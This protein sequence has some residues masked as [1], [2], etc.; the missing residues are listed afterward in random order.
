MQRILVHCNQTEGSL[1]DGLKDKHGSAFDRW[2]D[3]QC[4]RVLME[5]AAG[6]VTHA[7]VKA[8]PRGVGVTRTLRLHEDTYEQIRR[9]KLLGP[10]FV[11]FVLKWVI[12]NPS[13]SE[14]EEEYRQKIGVGDPALMTEDFLYLLLRHHPAEHNVFEIRVLRE[15][16][17]TAARLADIEARLASST[18]VSELASE[19]ARVRFAR[20]QPTIAEI[21][22]APP[23]LLDFFADLAGISTDQED[24]RHAL[25]KEW[26][27]L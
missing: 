3:T 14:L 27:L 19:G 2:F 17:T 11:R 16:R 7:D 18:L 24:L 21:D 5:L 15:L 26:G 6:G 20:R 22:A 9:V 4:R 1:V 10:A 12:R 23:W 13:Q 25:K 8:V